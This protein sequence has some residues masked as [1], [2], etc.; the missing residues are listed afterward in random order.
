MVA[1]DVT[2]WAGDPS[3]CLTLSDSDQGQL[4]SCCL[5][6][7]HHPSISVCLMFDPQNHCQNNK[8][9]DSERKNWRMAYYLVYRIFLM[10]ET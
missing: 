8:D 5:S 1:T 2:V 7:S 6:S 3:L 9:G 4:L 10:Y